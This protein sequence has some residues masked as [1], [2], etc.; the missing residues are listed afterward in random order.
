M[1]IRREV[2]VEAVAG[3]R[4]RDPRLVVGDRLSTLVACALALAGC[5]GTTGFPPAAQSTSGS[6]AAE[7]GDPETRT[8]DGILDA[9]VVDDRDPSDLFDVTIQYTDR[10][11]PDV[12][13]QPEGGTPQASGVD[14]PSSWPSCAPDFPA[15]Q[16]QDGGFVPLL[17]ASFVSM[18]ARFIP[19]VFTADGGE[20]PATP[21]TECATHVWLGNAACDACVR[22]SAHDQVGVVGEFGLAALPPCSDLVGAGA[23]STGPG[24]GTSR[25]TL[26]QDLFECILQNQCWNTKNDIG[27]CFCQGEATHCNSS[28]GDGVCFEKLQRAMEFA[29]LSSPGE[30]FLQLSLHFTDIANSP[31]PSS[32][33]HGAQTVTALFT[34]IRNDCAMFCLHDGGLPD[35]H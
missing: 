24:A 23:P 11:L 28:G 4:Q 13:A 19:A 7:A 22:R 12:H 3:I 8:D 32:P 18:P 33:G 21:G 26:C 34:E 5:G 17:D 15:V 1:A 27:G 20:A 9:T 29:S 25:I 31:L 35:A 30:T 2:Q 10:A 6:V 14:G 16:G